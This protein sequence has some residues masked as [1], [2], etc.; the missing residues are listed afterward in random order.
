MNWLVLVLLVLPASAFVLLPL[1]CHRSRR[2]PAL[3]TLAQTNADLYREKMADLARQLEAEEIDER[4]RR[5]LELEAKR[6]LLADTAEPEGDNSSAGA[7]RVL[8]VAVALAVPVLALAL[9]GKLGA[10]DELRLTQLL[11]QRQA[12]FAQATTTPEQTAA[13]EEQLQR[14]LLALAD[15]HTDLPVYRL[16]LARQYQDQGN[17]AEAVVH[18]RRVLALAPG[19]TSLLAEY[20]QALFFASG[21]RVTAEVEAAMDQVLRLDPA[22]PTVLGLQGIA[23]FHAGDYQGA[24]DQWQRALA[25][26]PAQS[27]GAEA[28]RAGIANARERLGLAAAEV[29]AAAPAAAYSMTLEVSL[30]PALKAPPQTPVFVY[31]RAW[32]GSPMPLAIRRLTVADLP[33]SVVL[34]ETMA[35]TQAMTL[36]T[37]PQVELVA[38]V[39][40][41]GAAA[42]ASG[43]IEGRSGPHRPGGDGGPIPVAINR[44]LP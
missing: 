3:G 14:Q 24:I 1:W 6:Q 29:E 7:G 44:V 21:N 22:N 26:T 4:Q 41:S 36:A 27:E 43:D 28:L 19:Q 12:L 5:E 37:V 9:Y 16:M 18:L 25:G 31:A 11:A 15:K 2:G 8:L 40:L 10:P 30:D 17:F 39:A 23:R 35:M 42:P 38:R 34:D 20:A 33:A 13:I 32:Q